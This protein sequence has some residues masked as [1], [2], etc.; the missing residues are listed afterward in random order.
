M[1][2]VYKILLIFL[3]FLNCTTNNKE[4]ESV[5]QFNLTQ[6]KKYLLNERNID[7]EN[8]C[9]IIDSIPIKLENDK[10]LISLKIN[11]EMK[12]SLLPPP[13]IENY[14]DNNIFCKA[15][16]KCTDSVYVNF[17]KD[18]ILTS[19]MLVFKTDKFLKKFKG[20]NNNIKNN[21]DLCI[22]VFWDRLNNEQIRSNVN[23]FLSKCKEK[24]LKILF[25]YHNKKYN[26][27]LP[28]LYLPKL[29]KEN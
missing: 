12:H 24:K 1:A 10:Y 25:S 8:Y 22:K 29:P 16:Y 2:K 11:E 5:E 28:F 6:I 14:K 7:I 18:S 13:P 20:A 23:N 26:D 15:K 4:K 17:Q 27:T 3:L 19:N 9:G 21:Y